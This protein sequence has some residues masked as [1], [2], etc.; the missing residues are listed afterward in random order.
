MAWR[1]NP[2]LQRVLWFVAL[3]SAGVATLALV[4]WGIRLALGL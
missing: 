2:R 1:A 3:W 4:A